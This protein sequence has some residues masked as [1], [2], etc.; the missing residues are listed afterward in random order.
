MSAHVI[1][2]VQD[3]G[4]SGAGGGEIIQALPYN[5]FGSFP[6]VPSGFELA[7][8]AADISNH[9]DP[10]DSSHYDE[11]AT[12]S[13]REIQTT[14]DAFADTVTS[15][16]TLESTVVPSG[17]PFPYSGANATLQLWA[18]LWAVSGVPEPENYA[19]LLAG[20]G[21]IGFVARRRV[22]AK[23]D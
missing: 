11:S 2:T 10:R 14:Q 23:E 20:L 21:L 12:Y 19:M 6:V 4:L 13:I 17:F 1:L 16:G 8:A 3:Q 18:S 9:A 15:S 22:L 7:Y 5:P